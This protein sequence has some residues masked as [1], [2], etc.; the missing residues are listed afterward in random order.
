[1][2]SA[3]LAAVGAGAF[4]DY[5]SAVSSMVSYL[6]PLPSEPEAQLFYEEKYQRY[7]KNYPLVRH[8]YKGE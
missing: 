1:M 2:G 8:S 6:A 3:M 4:P 5:I 7:C